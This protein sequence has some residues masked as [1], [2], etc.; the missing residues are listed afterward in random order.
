MNLFTQLDEGSRD[1]SMRVGDVVTHFANILN[2][3]AT[4]ACQI[5]LA[6]M[7]HDIGKIKVPITILNKPDKLTNEEYTI[8]KQHAVYGSDMMQNLF[9]PEVCEMILY[10]HENM[11]G[12]GYYGK[13]GDEIPIG[14]RI[15]HICDVYDALISDRPYRKGWSRERT[16]EYMRENAGTMFD[17]DMLEIFFDILV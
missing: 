8:V 16:I 4:I 3:D 13:V 1:H 7:Y 10:H 15:I 9:V 11:D 5:S 14:S 6:A 2:L 12:T 17:K